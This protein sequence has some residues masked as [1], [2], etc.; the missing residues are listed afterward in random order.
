MGGTGPEVWVSRKRFH[1]QFRPDELQF[2]AGGLPDRVAAGLSAMHHVL[3][4]GRR[5]YG[6]MQAIL[7]SLKD[8]SVSAA[9]DP[10]GVGS[11]WVGK[12]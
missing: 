5:P 1:H 2:E 4:P 7:W 3:K 8:Q 10:R 6:N 11:A 12:P 9:S